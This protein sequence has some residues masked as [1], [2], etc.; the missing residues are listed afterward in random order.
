MLS[1]LLVPALL[2]C[3][4]RISCL[5]EGLLFCVTQL[6]NE[7]LDNVVDGEAADQWLVPDDIVAQET[8]LHLVKSCEAYF[9]KDQVLIEAPL[10][11]GVPAH[12]GRALV[13]EVETQG[14]D[15]VLEATHHLPR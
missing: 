1:L 15:Q 13:H 8:C 9:A 5:D 14:A 2:D 6:V 7:L 11:E 3:P 10:T 12:S 4:Q